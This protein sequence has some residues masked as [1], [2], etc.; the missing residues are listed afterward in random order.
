MQNRNGEN[1]L[2]FRKAGYDEGIQNYL[3]LS[4]YDE[5]ISI[6]DKLLN[7]LLFF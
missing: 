1:Y 3:S 6:N 2:D 4:L 7:S 5:N